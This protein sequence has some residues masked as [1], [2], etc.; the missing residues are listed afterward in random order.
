MTGVCLRAPPGIGAVHILSGHRLNVG[1]EGTVEMSAEDAECLLRAG[2]TKIAEPSC[3][4][5][6]LTLSSSR[7]LSQLGDLQQ[8]ALSKKIS[9]AGSQS[10]PNVSLQPDPSLQPEA[11]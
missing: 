1:P 11:S 4:E 9:I 3:A 7:A 8:T 6:S 10:D 5:C 2:W